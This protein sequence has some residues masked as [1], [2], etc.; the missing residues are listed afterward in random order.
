MNIIYI[1]CFFGKNIY[2]YIYIV[3][4]ERILFAHGQI[5]ALKKDKKKEK[6]KQKKE[7]CHS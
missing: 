4:F 6:K 3:F 2:I 5:Q 1:Y 7:E